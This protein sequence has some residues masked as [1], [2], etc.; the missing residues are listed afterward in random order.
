MP[1]RWLCDV[2]LLCTFIHIPIF[3]L[4]CFCLIEHVDEMVD[5]LITQDRAP[6]AF[7]AE[8]LSG[9]AGGVVLP[10]SYLRRVYARLR[11]PS[12]GALCICDEVQTGYGRLGHGFWGF[13]SPEHEALMPDII[14]V[15][16]AA[17]NG[18]PLGYVV[19]SQSILDEFYAAQGSFFSSAGG[20]PV[21][22]AIGRAVL[23]TVQEEALQAHS[24]DVGA[25]LATGLRALQRKHPH[26][27]GYIHGYGLYQG[28]EI[29][30]WDQSPSTTTSTTNVAPGKRA[31]TK[32]ARL[33][34]RRL[35][36]LGIICHNTGDYSNVLKV[37]PPLCFSKEDALYFM[38]M[39]DK[40]CTEGW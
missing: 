22:C 32:E 10:K 29:I 34:C 25:I 11:D 3:A 24:A 40:I 28:V 16:K 17:G 21:S 5:T 31:G 20:G 35:L 19:T 7:I 37:K 38:A 13:E 1:V 23:R 9:N 39:L 6:T 14:T 12:V 36:D 18:H 8:P 27:I 4:P 30:A 15:A 2:S 33:I 26:I